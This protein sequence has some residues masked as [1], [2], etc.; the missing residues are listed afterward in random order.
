MAITITNR[1]R[2][3]LIIEL[4]NGEAIYLAPDRK[5]DPIEEALVDGNEK[6][7]K[8][9]RDNLITSA[10]AEAETPKPKKAKAGK[11]S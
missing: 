5:S 4:N 9:L 11:N 3:L 2:Q 7:S 8:L 10:A 1:T 6:I